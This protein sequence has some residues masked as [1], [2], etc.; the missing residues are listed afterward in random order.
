MNRFEEAKGNIHKHGYTMTEQDAFAILDALDH[1]IAHAAN[2]PLT[3]RE[4]IE[5]ED[6]YAW[7]ITDG[8]PII[9]KIYEYKKYTDFLTYGVIGNEMTCFCDAR[10]ID[11][12][13]VLFYDCNYFG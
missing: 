12:G 11:E 1:M 2:E 9:V 3:L 5:R 8:T 6:K 7:K 10:L 4:L 13:K